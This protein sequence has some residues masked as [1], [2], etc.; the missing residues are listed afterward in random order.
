MKYLFLDVL[1]PEEVVES[2]ASPVLWFAFIGVFVLVAALTV[3]LLVKR[4]K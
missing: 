2:G 3:L 4:H 1:P